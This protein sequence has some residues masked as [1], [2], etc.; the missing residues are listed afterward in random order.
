MK[1]NINIAILSHGLIGR[2]LEYTVDSFRKNVLSPLK[3]VGNV[4]IFYHAWHVDKVS[5]KYSGENNNRIDSN[6]ITELLPEAKG[7]IEDQNKWDSTIDWEKH[8]ENNPFAV[9]LNIP[10]ERETMHTLKNHKRAIMSQKRAY[11]FFENNKDKKYDMVVVARLDVKYPEEIKIPKIDDIKKYKEEV[12]K[13]IWVPNMEHLS[14]INDRFAI[15]D[16]DAIKTWSDRVEY[17]DEWT[18]NPNGGQESE[19]LMKE[20]LNDRG[21]QI[22]Y[23]NFV[24]QR[25][26]AGGKVHKSDKLFLKNYLLYKLSAPLRVVH[27]CLFIIKSKIFKK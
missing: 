7:I 14:G 9:S 23:L 16:E 20:F 21:Y 18:L 5:N 11:V 1:K 15:G 12:K 26:R 10:S 13:I 19:W 3:K 4:D 6:I 22:K 27:R 17:S 24:F 8:R 2:S 25:V